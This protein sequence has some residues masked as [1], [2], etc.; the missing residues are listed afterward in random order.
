MVEAKGKVGLDWGVYCVPETSVVD[1]ADFV[2]MK[3][4]GPL[5]EEAIRDK[6]EPLIKELGS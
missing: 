4:I 1:K 2:R 6:L 3:H 5:N